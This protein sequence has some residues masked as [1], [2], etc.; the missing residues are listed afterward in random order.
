MYSP[1]LAHSDM[2]SK[3]K[4]WSATNDGRPALDTQT[5]RQRI[6]LRGLWMTHRTLDRGAICP[7]RKTSR[8]LDWEGLVKETHA[9]MSAPVS[10]QYSL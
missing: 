6:S 1:K 7:L 10:P 3:V 4:Q 8:E 2:G 9:A 5:S